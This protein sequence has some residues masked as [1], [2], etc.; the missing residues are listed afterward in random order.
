MQILTPKLSY[1]EYQPQKLVHDAYKITNRFNLNV[2]W[3]LNEHTY[4]TAPHMHTPTKRAHAHIGNVL[5]CVH[6]YAHTHSYSK[7]WRLKRLNTA[8]AGRN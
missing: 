3:I 1:S 5:N 7:Y 4:H 6:T 2:A 8:Y